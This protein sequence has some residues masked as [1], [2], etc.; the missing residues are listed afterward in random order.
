V[1]R[2]LQKETKVFRKHLSWSMA[3]ILITLTFQVLLHREHTSSPLH[4]PNE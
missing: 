4:R 2:E 1:K 3:F